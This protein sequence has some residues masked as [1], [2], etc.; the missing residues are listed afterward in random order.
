MDR[1]AVRAGQ[2][3]TDRNTQIKGVVA[4]RID[5]LP[6]QS[7]VTQSNQSQARSKKPVWRGARC[8]RNGKCGQGV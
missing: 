6:N 7:K 3:E 1:P 5:G 2:G 4:M 8:G